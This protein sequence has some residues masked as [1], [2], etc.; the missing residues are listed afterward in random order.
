M[1]FTQLSC[2]KFV[3]ELASKAP[4]PGGGG[5][6][7]LVG[8]VGAALGNM[9][10]SLTVGKKKYADV[11]EDI[12]ALKAKAD[13]LQAELLNLVE[14]D[15]EV[16]E[17]LSRA[18]GLPKDSPQELAERTKVMEAALKNACSVP[19]L[20]MGKCGE[21]VELHR[22]FAAK[23]TALAISDVGVGVALC[24]AALQ[25]ASLNVFINTKAMTDRAEAERANARAEELL[26]K[27]TDL[28]DE[29]Y[30]AVAAR[31]F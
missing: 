14:R 26:D 2:E 17:P 19:L 15:A 18:Y 4:V 29:I 25:G 23:G 8:A 24:K 11:Q 27:Y 5:A 30:S 21:A 10:G 3:E 31:F 9:V 12:L 13:K 20:I 7:A 1:A 16:F 22:E 6:S 28:A